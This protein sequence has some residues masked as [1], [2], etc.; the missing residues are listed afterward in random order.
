VNG[1]GKSTAVKIIIETNAFKDFSNP[2]KFCYYADV[3]PFEYVRAVA[4]EPEIKYP[5]G[6]KKV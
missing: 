4:R 1:I 2:R 6:Q 3:A 5:T